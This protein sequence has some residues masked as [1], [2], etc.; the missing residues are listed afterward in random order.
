MAGCAGSSGAA[1]TTQQQA[2]QEA[3]VW[4]LVGR[5]GGGE[6]VRWLRVCGGGDVMLT[7]PL[8]LLGEGRGGG[9]ASKL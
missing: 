8:Q 2:L 6:G 1:G 7:L 3:G 4:V 9:Q 5:E